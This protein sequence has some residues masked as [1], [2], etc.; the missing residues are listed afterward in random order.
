MTDAIRTYDRVAGCPAELLVIKGMAAAVE[1]GNIFSLHVTPADEIVVALVDD[2]PV[3]FVA[4][5]EY[6][7]DGEIWI[8]FGYC[9]PEYRRKGHYRACI[10][11]LRE[12]A[13]QR[14][15]SRIHTAVHHDNMAA[16]ASIE[17]RGGQLQYL[18]Y[19]FP[20]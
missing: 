6:E 13:Q 9:L 3:A 8:A 5:A 19:V 4:F 2:V 11:R 17:E 14:G 10:A 12:V 15:Y 7:E 20:V 16:K 18:G 1:A